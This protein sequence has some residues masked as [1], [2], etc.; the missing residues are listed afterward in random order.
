MQQM[1][2]KKVRDEFG[3][4]T[5][6]PFYEEDWPAFCHICGQRIVLSREFSNYKPV[7]DL[8][9]VFVDIRDRSRRK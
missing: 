3:Y 8:H 9:N 1:I 5:I 7:F 2:L 6:E 4:I